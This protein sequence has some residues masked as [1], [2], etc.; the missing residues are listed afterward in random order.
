MNGLLAWT[1][2]L[3]WTRIQPWTD[4]WHKRI[5][6][7]I[8]PWTKNE[9][10]TAYSFPLANN[11][12]MCQKMN[13]FFGMN[14]SYLVLKIWTDFWHERIVSMNKKILAR[15]TIQPWTEIWHEQKILPWTKNEPWTDY[16]KHMNGFLSW[17]DFLHERIVC[18][19]KK[20]YLE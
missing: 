14:D 11:P 16:S 19:N 13:E 20:S 5:I 8:M 12:F 7:K 1:N 3:P 2:S 6:G 18:M 4:S 15:T 10:W 9:P 17:M